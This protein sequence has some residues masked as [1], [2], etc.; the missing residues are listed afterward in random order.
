M[1]YRV[2]DEDQQE[3]DNLP[4]NQIPNYKNNSPNQHPQYEEEEPGNSSDPFADF[5]QKEKSKKG[6]DQPTAIQPSSNP[7]FEVNKNKTRKDQ[8]YECKGMELKKR[9]VTKMINP[10]NNNQKKDMNPPYNNQSKLS[11][12]EDRNFNE[13]SNSKNQ[14][15]SNQKK[16]LD[17]LN[18]NSDSNDFLKKIPVDK[19][20]MIEIQEHKSSQDLDKSSKSANAPNLVLNEKSKIGSYNSLHPSESSKTRSL[21]SQYGESNNPISETTQRVDIKFEEDTKTKNSSETRK[22]YE[23]N[24]SDNS[25][26]NNAI[27]QSSDPTQKDKLANPQNNIPYWIK[28]E[29]YLIV[30]ELKNSVPIRFNLKDIPSDLKDSHKKDVNPY[31]GPTHKIEAK[32]V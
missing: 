3:F 23:N 14:I 29:D 28:K 17:N 7:P 31:K 22:K 19:S 6:Q 32:Y 21:E 25:N 10:P 24:I 1:E 20:D 15:S 16:N 18:V 8:T 4:E 5:F 26:S 9:T 13:Q 2:G 27:L 30:V 12:Q 11:N